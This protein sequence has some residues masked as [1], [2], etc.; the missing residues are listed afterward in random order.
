[1]T[2]APVTDVRPASD[3]LR[4][5]RD[6]VDPVLRAAVDTI[7]DS[8]RHIIGYHLG[9]WDGGGRPVES[10]GGKGFRPALALLA[11]E[12]VGGRATD[13]AVVAAAVELVHNHS[14]VHDDL[15]DGDATRRHRPTAWCVFG[16]NAA[17]QAGDALLALA[18]GV[19]AGSGHPAAVEATRMLNAAAL[20][21][22]DGQVLDLTFERRADVSRS[23]CLR[24]TRAKTGA[25][26]ACACAAGA[27]FGGGRPEQVEH[28]RAF[29]E[30]LGMAFQ[31]VDDLLGIWGSPETTGKPVHSDLYSRKKSLPVVAALTSGTPAG[32]QVAA[33]YRRADPLSGTD[34]AG[35]ADL[36]DEAGGRAWSQ[37]LAGDEL[38]SARHHLRSANLVTQPA[39][40][41]DA[42]ARLA[43]HRDC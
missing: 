8:T 24:M 13:A 39:H 18:F 9:W 38:A 35:L 16:A 41:L 19:L 31:H 3:V 25:L 14:L 40:E 15:M 32:R 21:L 10:G 11:A 36:I 23:E 20:S 17:I 30:H 2:G 28:L 37:A 34:L 1:M 4:H 12:A 5:S 7:P 42:L 29:G 33:L 22:V 26:M 43:T 6:V 27:L